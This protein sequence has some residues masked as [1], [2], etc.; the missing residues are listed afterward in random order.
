MRKSGTSKLIAI[1]GLEEICL[2]R[3]GNNQ[4]PNPTFRWTEGGFILHIL[5]VP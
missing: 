5:W 4:Y 3:H 2:A 1:F